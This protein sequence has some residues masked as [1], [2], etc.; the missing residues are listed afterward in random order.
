MNITIKNT[1]DLYDK[2]LGRSIDK[3]KKYGTFLLKL[4]YRSSFYVHQQK[5]LWIIAWLRPIWLG[6]KA[7]NRIIFKRMEQLLVTIS[8]YFISKKLL[9][10][11]VCFHAVGDLFGWYF[12]KVSHIFLNTFI[13]PSIKFNTNFVIILWIYLRVSRL[14]NSIPMLKPNFIPLFYH[15]VGKMTDLNEP[16]EFRSG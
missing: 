16:D 1:T 6:T 12:M 14:I 3:P 13:L 8:T 7:I 10:I 11:E 2:E 15:I 9:Q 5:K 4:S